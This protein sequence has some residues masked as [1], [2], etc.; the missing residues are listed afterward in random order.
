M[1]EVVQ[2][3]K[4]TNH[5]ECA[6]VFDLRTTLGEKTEN[7]EGQFYSRKN[8]D[9]VDL[10]FRFGDESFLF[11]GGAGGGI[12]CSEKSRQLKSD[13]PV[14]TGHLL[15]F[16]DISMPFL[17]NRDC[18]YRCCRRVQGRNTHIIR[19]KMEEGKAV[20]IAYDPGF[21]AVLQIEYF[22]GKGELVR[23]FKLLNFKK[24][25]NIWLMKSLEIRDIPKKITTRLTIKKVATGTMPTT[26]FDRD[27]FWKTIPDGLV[28]GD[29]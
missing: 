9:A 6:F 4:G 26:V 17:E 8:G 25:Q 27:S 10:H 2:K 22:D 23:S 13:D 16:A 5:L 20:D 21:E 12:F 14:Q 3:I 28:Y 19:F 24:F 29:F 18:E 15:N 1:A 11:L 7:R